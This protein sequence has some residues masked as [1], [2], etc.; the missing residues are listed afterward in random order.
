MVIARDVNGYL[1]LQGVWSEAI[2]F[3]IGQCESKVTKHLDFDGNSDCWI[4]EGVA[5]KHL[6]SDFSDVQVP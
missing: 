2:P 1:P 4:N 3:S 5:D 6:H